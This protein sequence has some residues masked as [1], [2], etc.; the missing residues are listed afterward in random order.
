MRVLLLV[1][2]VDF[3][4]GIDGLVQVSREKVK[5]DPFSGALFLFR[6]RRRTAIK[7]IIY[8]GQGFWLLMKRLSE[9]K[10]RYWPEQT[11]VG[12]EV[13]ALLSRE[14]SVLLW[15]GD[16]SK[17]LMGSDWRKLAFFGIGI[18]LAGSVFRGT[19]PPWTNRRR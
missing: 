7:G 16:P 8:D 10:F 5:E 11:T 13:A 15:N 6:N 4:K 17:A 1:D 2:S 18:M 19:D 3:R 12:G 9:G 14:L